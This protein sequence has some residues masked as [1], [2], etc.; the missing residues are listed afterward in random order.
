MGGHENLDIQ[1]FLPH[2]I[3]GRTYLRCRD[4][5]RDPVH[6]ASA[7]GI[8][9]QGGMEDIVK[10]TQ[11]VG[12]QDLEVPPIGGIYAGIWVGRYGDLHIKAPEYGHAIHC[13]AT[14]CGPLPGGGSESGISCY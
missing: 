6:Q 2:H 9:P 13:D 4:L 5:G 7:G 12:G 3:S 1:E 10:S 14:Y 11:A 8:P